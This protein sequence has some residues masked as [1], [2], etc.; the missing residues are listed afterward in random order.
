MK[1]TKSFNFLFLLVVSSGLMITGYPVI[2]T[3]LL[4]IY[5]I[6]NLRYL[7]KLKIKN[8]KIDLFFIFILYLI[9]Q[10][11]RG[12]ILL[13]DLRISYWILFFIITYLS[14]KEIIKLS[15]N[16]K[17][18]DQY[19]SY[20]YYSSIIYFLIYSFIGIYIKDPNEF[21]GIFWVGSSVAFIV[22]IPLLAS[23]SIIKL[24][25]SKSKI[26]YFGGPLI[27][28]LCSVIHDSRIGLYILML[29]ILIV[30]L[31]KLKFTTEY[32]LGI[33]LTLILFIVIDFFGQNYYNTKP[34]FTKI[35]TI[36]D[37]IQKHDI[38][39][40]SF[41]GDLGRV[42]MIE[43]IVNKAVSTP[44]EFLFGSGW[45]TS[46]FTLKPF[47]KEIRASY[48]LSISHLSEE[49]S[50][51]TIALASIISDTGIF[52]GIIFI[53]L[54]LKASKQI[55]I[56]NNPNKYI[57]IY[58]LYSNLL[59]YLIGYTFVS[60]LSILLVLPSGLIVQLSKLRK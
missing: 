53:L 23:H 1:N 33:L 6:L 9:F 42:L 58:L 21:Q 16:L 20:I 57:Q 24:D 60:P 41:G 19:S 48:G 59:F 13:N 52:G 28:G 36:E 51:Q 45:Y 56:K 2:S 18:I 49:K 8:L 26:S 34:I 27:L 31:S 15:N 7:K 55:F 44:V 29:Y 11:I 46:R 37:V 47:E 32:I 30:I 40:E 12:I 10:T 22:A 39:E 50:L 3:F 43:S 17:S 25:N 35:I 5:F 38:N 4:L 14:Y 54:F